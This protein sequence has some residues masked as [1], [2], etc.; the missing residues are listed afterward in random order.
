MKKILQHGYDKFHTYCEKC[1]CY[2]A[3]E[4]SDVDYH[5]IDCPE[6]SYHNSHNIKNQVPPE[7]WNDLMSEDWVVTDDPAK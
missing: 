1:G 5:Y 6:C 3:Y 2:F 7:I 4:L